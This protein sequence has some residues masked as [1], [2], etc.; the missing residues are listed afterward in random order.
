M[1][2]F[3]PAKMQ[4][5]GRLLSPLSQKDTEAGAQVSANILRCSYSS[6]CLDRSYHGCSCGLSCIDRPHLVKQSCSRRCWLAGSC[7]AALAPTTHRTYRCLA[8]AHVLPC[9]LVPLHNV[10]CRVVMHA[11]V[12]AVVQCLASIYDHNT[13][14]CL[15][16]INCTFVCEARL[17]G[18]LHVS[19]CSQAQL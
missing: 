17:K 19:C 11:V 7:W 2:K 1:P 10:F 18:I 9:H 16:A 15:G 14:Y 4:P 13:V 3:W 5:R 12:H 8:T 6:S